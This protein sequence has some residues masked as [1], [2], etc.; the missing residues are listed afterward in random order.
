MPG[1]LQS[2]LTYLECPECGKHF[3]AKRLQ[4]FCSGRLQAQRLLCLI[5][6]VARQQGKQQAEFRREAETYAAGLRVPGPFA[7]RLILRA[8]GSKSGHGD[9]CDR[10]GDWPRTNEMAAGEGLLGAATWAALKHPVKQ[11]WVKP[12]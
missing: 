3:D 11:G 12:G 9:R 5:Q 8:I 4:T 10:R 2:S 1:A 7:D 6:V